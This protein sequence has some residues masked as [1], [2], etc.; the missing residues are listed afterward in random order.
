VSQHDHKWDVF[1][2]DRDGRA[3]LYPLGLYKRAANEQARSIARRH[4]EFVLVIVVDGWADNP[5]G[6]AT[7]PNVEAT[8]KNFAE[9]IDNRHGQASVDVVPNTT[10][11]QEGIMAT[12][13]QN[14][15]VEAAEDTRPIVRLSER[16]PNP[17]KPEQLIYEIR[18]D[19]KVI[20]RTFATTRVN[21]KKGQR[22]VYWTAQ[23]GKGK[24]TGDAR[25]AT[26]EAAVLKGTGVDHQLIW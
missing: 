1:C 22:A 6:L 17:R 15:Q 24:A 5:G 7:T 23:V 3:C 11:P 25:K 19:G 4:P 13:E 12:V 16:K 26:V 9:K 21:R 14:E 18:Q 10:T 20:G 8:A 2:R